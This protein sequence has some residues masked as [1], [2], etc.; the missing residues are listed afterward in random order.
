VRAAAAPISAAD[1]PGEYA[2]D[3]RP[4]VEATRGGQAP[5][6]TASATVTTEGS[7]TEVPRI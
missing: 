2:T 5:E 7:R 1:S 6:A 4:V 3:T